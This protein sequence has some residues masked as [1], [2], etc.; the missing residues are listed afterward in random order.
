MLSASAV[1]SSPCAGSDLLWP[2]IDEVIGIE[3][4]ILDARDRALPPLAPTGEP[5]LSSIY[6]TWPMRDGRLP[7]DG[8][9]DPNVVEARN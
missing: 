8:D 2:G 6:S 3:L 7:E 9:P 4:Y 5:G 1:L